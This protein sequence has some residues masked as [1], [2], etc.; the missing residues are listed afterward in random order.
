MEIEMETETELEIEREKNLSVF[1][2]YM[3]FTAKGT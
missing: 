2:I 3:R 1:D